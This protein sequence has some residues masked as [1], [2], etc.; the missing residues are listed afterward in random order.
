MASHSKKGAK[1]R[2]LIGFLDES[3]ISEKPTVRRTWAPKGHTPIIRSTGSWKTRSVVGV[4]TSTPNGY[5]P[6]LYLRIFKTTIHAAEVIRFIKELRYHVKRKVILLWDGLPAHRAK[7]VRNFLKTQTHWLETKRFPAYA[8]ELNPVEY[9]WSSGKT[10]DL[11]NFCPDT[12]DILDNQIR[13]S[14][15]RLRRRPDILK[16]FLRKSTLF[17]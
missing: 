2:A 1:I 14:K 9:A 6:K 5:R 17:H 16:G 3:G 13:R 10:K 7:T 8:P 4:I 15:R 12:L 11:A